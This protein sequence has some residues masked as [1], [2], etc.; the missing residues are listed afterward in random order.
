MRNLHAWKTRTDDGRKR[1]VNARLFGGIWT[2]RARISGEELWTSYEE[3]LL[4][5]LLALREVLFAK[6]QRKHLAHEHLTSVEKLIL[7]RGATWEE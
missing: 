5:D 3:P 6:Y 2:F 4:E 1:E 7:A